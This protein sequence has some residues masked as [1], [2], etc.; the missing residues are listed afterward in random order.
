MFAA[1]SLRFKSSALNDSP[2]LWFGSHYPGG[3]I[4]K[5]WASYSS[6]VNI[7][8]SS[9]GSPTRPTSFAPGGR[10]MKD[11]GNKVASR[12]LAALPLLSLFF[13]PNKPPAMQLLLVVR[14]EWL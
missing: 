6:S 8:I 9:F 10:K 5:E 1:L 4:P 11:P 13:T 12:F 14:G 7:W 3:Q 2:G